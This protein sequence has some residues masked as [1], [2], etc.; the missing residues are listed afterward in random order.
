MHGRYVSLVEEV[1]NKVGKQTPSEWYGHIQAIENGL[2][3]I[4]PKF[5]E[6]LEAA[7]PYLPEDYEFDFVAIGNKEV[8]FLKMSSLEDPHPHVVE[9]LKVDTEGN[10]RQGKTNKQ[11]YHRLETMVSPDHYTYPFHKAVTEWEE[12]EGLLNFDGKYPSGSYR[13][14]LEQIEQKT[15]RTETDLINKWKELQKTYLP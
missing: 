9:S 3:N 13:R 4:R 11:I 8:R 2:A 14:W 6:K 5:Q 10:V 7:R 1:I 15:G 12:S